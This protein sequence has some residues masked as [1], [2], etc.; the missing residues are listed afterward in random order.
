M[1][2]IW[3]NSPTT[4]EKSP[5]NFSFH[6][7]LFYSSPINPLSLREK[8]GT[9]YETLIRCQITVHRFI[10]NVTRIEVNHLY[11]RRLGG[12]GERDW[13]KV[14]VETL[15]RKWENAVAEPHHHL[16]RT[17]RYMYILD[18]WDGKMHWFF[19][20]FE[21]LWSSRK[22]MQVIISTI[23]LIIEESVFI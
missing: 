1:T 13:E 21:C 12:G 3:W 22:K 20:C 8:R 14:C 5:Y 15:K 2:N 6:C 18:R 9:N 11:T 23:L 17:P 16:I 7:R 10:T 19:S 4:K